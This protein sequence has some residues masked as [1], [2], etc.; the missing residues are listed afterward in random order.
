MAA[1]VAA[2]YVGALSCVLRRSRGAFFSHL[3]GKGETGPWL[4]RRASAAAP[5]PPRAP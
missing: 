5:R 1:T 3:L 4:T 2:G